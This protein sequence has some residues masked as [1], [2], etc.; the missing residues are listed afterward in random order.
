MSDKARL[1]LVLKI[2]SQENLP[3]PLHL[4]DY[5]LEFEMIQKDNEECQ[6]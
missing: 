2:L 4:L 3:Q 5:I 1:N 6:C